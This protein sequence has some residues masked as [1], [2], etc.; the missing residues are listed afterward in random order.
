LQSACGKVRSSGDALKENSNF[1]G[2]MS[3]QSSEGSVLTRSWLVSFAVAA[4][5]LLAGCGGN[6]IRQGHLFQDEDVNQVHEGMTKDQVV[7]ALGTP[8]TQSTAGGGAY[9][10]ISQTAVQKVHFLKPEVTDRRVVAVYFSNKDRVE[11]IASYGMKDGKVF[12]FISRQTPAYSRDRGLL[13]ELFRNI[14]AAPA[15]PGVNKDN[16]R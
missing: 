13:D 8:D 4:C 15:M 11:K 10:Y 14:G 1:E 9:Y 2:Q 3:N 6:V 7:L 12:D 16:S 5:L